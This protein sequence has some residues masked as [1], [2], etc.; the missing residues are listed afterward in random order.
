MPQLPEIFRVLADDGVYPLAFHC[1]A[2]KDRSGLV[3][4]LVLSALGVGEEQVVDDY[5]QSGA[6]LKALVAHV[7]SIG[8]G[9]K[10]HSAPDGYFDS[11][12]DVMQSLLARLPVGGPVQP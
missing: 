6:H 10:V 11:P 5:A 12:A 8:A 7:R 9:A 3:A 2:G 1:V 4:A